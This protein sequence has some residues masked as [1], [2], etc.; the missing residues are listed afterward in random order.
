[1]TTSAPSDDET[2]TKACG[3]CTM[4]CKIMAIDELE[5]PMGAWCPHCQP[6]V[7]CK[8]YDERPPSCRAFKCYWLVDP[9]MAQNLRPD[10]TKVV[11]D[12]DTNGHRMIARCAPATPLAWRREPMYSGLKAWARDVWGHGGM[13]LA[14]AGRRIWIITPRQDVDIGEVDPRSPFSVEEQADGSIKVSI[15]PP[16]PA[17]EIFEPVIRPLTSTKLGPAR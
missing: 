8:I 17:G 7:G 2:L 3:G 9:T 16:L 13:V 11:L 1:M 5:K 12:Q 10:R 6:G 4:C 15:L 14:M